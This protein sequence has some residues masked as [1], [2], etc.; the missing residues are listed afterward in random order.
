MLSLIILSFHGIQPHFG[1]VQFGATKMLTFRRRGIEIYFY[2]HE[3][4][5]ALYI[6]MYVYIYYLYVC[7]KCE[8]INS[9]HI[10]WRQFIFIFK[11]ISLH[12]LFPV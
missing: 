8:L 2:V 7:E 10:I 4:H 12:K 9:T 6:C 5:A 11:K 1:N 3:L